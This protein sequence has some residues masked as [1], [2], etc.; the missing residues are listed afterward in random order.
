M[1]PVTQT[2]AQQQ[3]GSA[4]GQGFGQF[5][6]A[7]QQNAR[8]REQ[9]NLA[10]RQEDRLAERQR[11]LL[12]YEE[13]V[14][15][16]QVIDAGITAHSNRLKL[17][18]QIT[19]NKA[20]PE[21]LAL[22][23][24][25][26][27]SPRGFRDPD[28]RAAFKQL[29]DRYPQAFVEGAAGHRLKQLIQMPTVTDWEMQRLEEADKRLKGGQITSKIDPKG[30]ITTE[31]QVGGDANWQPSTGTLPNPSGGEPIPF[32]K[33]SPRSAQPM[34]EPRMEELTD[35]V[36]GERR[37]VLRTGMSGAR[38]MPADIGKRQ[39]E[40]F[41]R[42]QQADQ[43]KFIRD[44]QPQVYADLFSKS[45]IDPDTGMPKPT[46]EAIQ[47]AAKVAGFEPGTKAKMEEQMVAA[48]DLFTTA[49]EF[50][51]LIT[52]ENVGIRGAI[53]RWGA[54]LG[55]EGQPGFEKATDAQKAATMSRVFMASIFRT[56]RSD[57]NIAKPEVEAL[58]AAA[59]DTTRFIDDPD[60]IKSQ[61]AAL[62]RNA[63]NKDRNAAQRMGKPVSNFFLTPDEVRAR[64]AAGQ[65]P[66][67]EGLRIIDRS[68]WSLIRAL[69]ASGEAQR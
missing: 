43:L 39:Q 44:N 31:M 42:T 14:L 65:M 9:L 23:N 4:G 16:M 37:S 55:L 17:E 13:A 2:L 21:I 6:V 27:E 58:E 32:I 53:R 46:P 40:A 12:P 60:S 29:K 26:M 41:Q 48:E 56:L 67:D 69:T 49:Q 45:P 54:R 19:S 38:P 50:L 25:F 15:G 47:Q 36:T 18:N 35:P 7:G 62:L 20:L 51:P 10:R 8:Q 28:G 24:Y 68:A 22:E 63:N 34:M 3:S 11:R 5:F 57:S 66:A 64:V 33:T 30:Q 1:D 59:P 61:M 52:K